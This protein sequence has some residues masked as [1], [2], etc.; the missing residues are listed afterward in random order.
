MG[1][2]GNYSK[3]DG[4]CYGT[5][6][7]LVKYLGL[8]HHELNVRMDFSLFVLWKGLSF[9]FSSSVLSRFNNMYTMFYAS[10]ATKITVNI[11]Y[12]VPEE[13]YNRSLLYKPFQDNK[14]HPNHGACVYA[15]GKL[16]MR[17]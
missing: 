9:S 11:A 1:I 2:S 12:E 3:D 4:Q 7:D 15:S 14:E 13:I 8:A 17:K 5:V 16:R 10:F 6:V